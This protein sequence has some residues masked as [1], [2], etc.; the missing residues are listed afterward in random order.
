MPALSAESIMI[1]RFAFVNDSIILKKYYIDKTNFDLL[2]NSIKDDNN[3]KFKH[4]PKIKEVEYQITLKEL[5]FISKKLDIVE[6]NIGFDIERL[7]SLISIVNT[8]LTD[9]AIVK[10]KRGYVLENYKN[11]SAVQDKYLKTIN[12]REKSLNKNNLKNIVNEKSRLKY[13][14][15]NVGQANC[16]CLMVDNMPKV[17]FDLGSSVFNKTL[18]SFFE[19][20]DDAVIIISHFDNDHVNLAKKLLRKKRKSITILAP[21][22]SDVASLPLNAILLIICS[23]IA[24]CFLSFVSLEKD[25]SIDA[26]PI[27]VFQG[28]NKKDKN[29]S[30][31]RNARCL[32]SL[33][34]FRGKEIL[35]P[36]DSLYEE[37]P[38]SFEPNYLII[39]HHGCKYLLDDNQALLPNINEK[40]IAQSFVLCGPNRRYKHANATHLKHYWSRDYETVVYRFHSK[41]KDE[42]KNLIFDGNEVLRRENDYSKVLKEDYCDWVYI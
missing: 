38:C 12:Q 22:D 28:T 6:Q 5:F 29:Q 13:R 16:S 27:K 25:K 24:N 4:F 17:V 21:F 14:V 31:E 10:E 37:F 11:I 1:M 42:Y 33:I 20:L 39:P 8:N 19:K 35:I 40:K 32:I 2:C 26:M 34:S 41:E 9:K 18:Y 7:N 36:G 23:G 15:F 30:T 3:I